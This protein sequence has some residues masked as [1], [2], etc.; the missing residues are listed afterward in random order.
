MNACLNI[1][2]IH[3]QTKTLWN[4]IKAASQEQNTKI[5]MLEFTDMLVLNFS[6]NFCSCEDHI[7]IIGYF[8]SHTHIPPLILWIE[9]L[10]QT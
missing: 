10:H 5:E 2:K 4:W 6:I 8:N 3:T 1:W 7:A 9:L